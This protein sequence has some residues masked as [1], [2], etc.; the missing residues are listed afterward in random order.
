[1]TELH[2]IAMKLPGVQEGVAC[3]GTVVES[4]TIKVNGKAF[5][6]LRKAQAMLKLDGSLAE[7]RSLATK[8]PERYFPGSGG[9]VKIVWG[10]QKPPMSVMK[11]WIAE[12]YGLYA[13]GGKQIAGKKKTAKKKRA[14]R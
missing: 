2:A 9:W 12:S 11:R 14:K 4:R 3:A 10:D 8:E 6:F 5:L 13:G 7:A 1:M